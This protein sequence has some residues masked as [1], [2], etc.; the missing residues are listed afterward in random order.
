MENPP[1]TRPPR[2]GQ[3]PLAWRTPPGTRAPWH[4]EPP[5]AWRT[6]PP[7]RPPPREADCGIRST[8]GRYAS[9]WNAFLLG[10][11]IV[12]WKKLILSVETLTTK[13]KWSLNQILFIRRFINRSQIFQ[14]NFKQQNESCVGF[15][16]AISILSV[17]YS[18][19]QPLLI[20][21]CRH[22]PLILENHESLKHQLV[23]LLGSVY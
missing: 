2:H 4:G 15:D 6:P 5:L 11:K 1:G 8:I 23:H 18:A 3:S 22:T 17:Q 21:L 7:W 10:W 13:W 19:I 9:Y 14:D 12:K 16:P 20:N